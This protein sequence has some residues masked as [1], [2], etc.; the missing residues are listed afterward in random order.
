[1]LP[2]SLGH[3]AAP[4]MVIGLPSIAALHLPL[5]GELDL[6][7][8]SLMW[9]HPMCFYEALFMVDDVSERAMRKVTSQG[10]EGVQVTFAK[11]GDAI[12]VV[13]QLGV[14]ARC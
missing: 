6:G 10:R 7:K 14:E 12:V 13:A 8:G 2:E 4:R 1:M 5:E 9:T 3:I 11:M